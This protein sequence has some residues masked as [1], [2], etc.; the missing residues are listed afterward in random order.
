MEANDL[1]ERVA[2]AVQTGGLSC[3]QV[4]KQFAV[5]ISTAIIWVRRLRETGSVAD[6]SGCR[7]KSN[8]LRQMRHDP[9]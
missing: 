7:C 3:N 5:A 9:N 4:A 8:A 1:R 6:R 2:A